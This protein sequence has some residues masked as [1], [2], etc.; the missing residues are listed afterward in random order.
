MSSIPIP[1]QEQLEMFNLTLLMAGFGQPG[2]SPQL[3]SSWI[4]QIIHKETPS[5]NFRL[6][7]CRSV[8][9]GTNVHSSLPPLLLP[10]VPLLL[11]K[12]SFSG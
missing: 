6:Q 12:G 4:P 1:I 3:G 8:Q 7:M 2:V 11:A 9:G 10:Q 5:M